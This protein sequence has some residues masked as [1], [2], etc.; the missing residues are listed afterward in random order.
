MLY[1]EVEFVVKVKSSTTIPGGWVGQKGKI[2]ALLNS[3]EVKVE[4]GVELGKRCQVFP[5]LLT[6]EII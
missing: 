3:V 5:D 2:N 6:H 1:L 4:V